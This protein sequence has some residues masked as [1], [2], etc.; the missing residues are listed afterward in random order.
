[1]KPFRSDR[2][3]SKRPRPDGLPTS[4]SIGDEFR[5]RRTGEIYRLSNMVSY[6]HRGIK[7]DPGWKFTNENGDEVFIPKDAPSPESYR[8]FRRRLVETFE[9]PG[10]VSRDAK[11]W[12]GDGI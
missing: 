3:A 8:E 5:H 4:F 6:N 12:V 10:F 2:D 7:E 11:D 1:M 9:V